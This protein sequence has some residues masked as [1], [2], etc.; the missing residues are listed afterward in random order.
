MRYIRS[1]DMEE[2]ISKEILLKSLN[3]TLAICRPDEYQ[4]RHNLLI[5][6]IALFLTQDL[7]ENEEMGEN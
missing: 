6:Q 5:R 3:D 7:L 4:S 1:Q 2:K